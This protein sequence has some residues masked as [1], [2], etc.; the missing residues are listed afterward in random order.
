[1]SLTLDLSLQAYSVELCTKN[2]QNRVEKSKLFF[3]FKLSFSSLIVG[4]VLVIGTPSREEVQ[5]L[6]EVQ[7]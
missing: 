4:R 2:V 5:S 3:F 1:M 6:H 7:S